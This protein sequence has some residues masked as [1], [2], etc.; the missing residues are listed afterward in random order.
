MTER[1]RDDPAAR[2]M[3]E[4]FGARQIA[5]VEQWKVRNAADRLQRCI[6]RG[7]ADAEA[8]AALDLGLLLRG[9][10]D[11]TEADR[12]FSRARAARDPEVV[13]EAGLNLGYL[14]VYVNGD[15]AGALAAFERVIG[16]GPS[17][18]FAKAQACAAHVLED[19]GELDRARALC[20]AASHSED[21]RIATVAKEQLRRLKKKTGAKPFWK[22]W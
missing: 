12:A 13:A 5:A 20:E 7:D 4:L 9:T 18:W 15:P 22:F 19:L 16:L 6:K 14:R 11:F 10:R 1:P 17:K 3:E 21:R 8:E 2:R